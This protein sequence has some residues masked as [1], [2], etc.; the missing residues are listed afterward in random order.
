MSSLRQALFPDSLTTRPPDVRV[1]LRQAA[2]NVTSSYDALV[3]L[4]ECVGGFLKRLEIYS[5]IPS[6]PLMSDIIIKIMVEVL[7]VLAL[8]TEQIKNGIFSQWRPVLSMSQLNAAQR[9]LL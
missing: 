9:N 6:S 7:S 1:L 5:N 2:S 4:F 8:A 3:E